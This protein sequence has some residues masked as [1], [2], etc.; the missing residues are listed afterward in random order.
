MKQSF[1]RL[2]GMVILL[3]CVTFFGRM[4]WKNFSLLPPLSLDRMLLGVGITVVGLGVL[5]HLLQTYVVHLLLRGLGETPV[6][7]RVS[8]IVLVTQ[9]AKY[10]PGN[11]GHYV[12][13]VALGKKYGYGTEHLLFTLG[14]EIG[15]FVVVAILVGGIAMLYAGHELLPGHMPQMSSLWL[16]ALGVVVLI[17]MPPLST[18]VLKRWRP[19][20]IVKLLGSNTVDLPPMHI[21]VACMLLLVMVFVVNSLG[22]SLLS[23]ALFGSGFDRYSV[24]IGVFSFAWLVGFV[25]PGAPGGLGVREALLVAGLGPVLGEPEAITLAIGSRLCFVIGDGMAFLL[26]LTALRMWPPPAVAPP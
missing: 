10:L 7:R 17:A 6:F 19:P 16:M 18:L 9:F 14:Y 24:I 15:W 13:R 20:M 23:E 26:G 2:V 25:I 11:V 12:G 3:L 21:T 4:L 8:A 1:L 5:V 22:L